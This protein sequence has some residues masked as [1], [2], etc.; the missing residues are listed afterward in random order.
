MYDYCCTVEFKDGNYYITV[1]PATDIRT[2]NRAFTYQIRKQ[3]NVDS[4]KCIKV[5]LAEC[6]R[7]RVA[8][9]GRDPSIYCD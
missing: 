9:F 4:I 6:V 5:E 8:A 3:F 1:I 2:A 7:R